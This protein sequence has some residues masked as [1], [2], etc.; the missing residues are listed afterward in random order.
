MIPLIQRCCFHTPFKLQNLTAPR[1][2]LYGK[3]K[4][5]CS[6]LGLRLQRNVCP[7][8]RSPHL[9]VASIYATKLQALHTSLPFFKKKTPKEAEAKAG[10]LKRSMES[11]KDSPKPALYLSLAGLIPF[12]SI[13]LSMAIQGTYYPELASAQIM[14]GAVTVSFLGGMRW[15]FALPENSPA[16]PD[17]LNLANSTIPPL[18]ACQALLFKDVTQGAVMLV[19]ALGIALHYDVSLLPTYPRWFKVLRVVGTLVMVFSLLATAALK[20]ISELEQSNSRNEWQ[21]TK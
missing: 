7:L 11:L 18:F 13:P 17:W 21:N 2:L 3:N 4:T 12:V 6:S 20:A 15:G 14:Y 16:K 1:L 19:M 10:V 5:A 9:N 8:S